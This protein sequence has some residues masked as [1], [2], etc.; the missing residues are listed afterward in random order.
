MSGKRVLAPVEV[1]DVPSTGDR[2]DPRV[3][4]VLDREIGKVGTKLLSNGFVPDQSHRIE[5]GGSYLLD[6][7]RILTANKIT[8]RSTA[9]PIQGR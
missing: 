7:E 8:T 1:R 4:F 3:G 9:K 2:W 6:F 5:P